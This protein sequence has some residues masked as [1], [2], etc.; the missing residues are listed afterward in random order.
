[1]STVVQREVNSHRIAC[2]WSRWRQGD[3]SMPRLECRQLV[4][5]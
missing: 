2:L 5:R 4:Q 1:L 3:T